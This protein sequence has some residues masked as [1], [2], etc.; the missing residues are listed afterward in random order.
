MLRE[1]SVKGSVAGMR[2]DMYDA[3]TLLLHY[4]FETEAFTGTVFPP[5]DVQQAFGMLGDSPSSL[6]T[7][8]KFG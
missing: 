4:R 7:Q 5:D 1:N 6:K 8:I 3:M 2:E